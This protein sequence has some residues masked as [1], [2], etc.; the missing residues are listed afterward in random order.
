MQDTIARI[1]I[2]TCWKQDLF[3]KSIVI[4]Y[5]RDSGQYNF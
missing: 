5:F 3:S 4:L 1:G 2:L